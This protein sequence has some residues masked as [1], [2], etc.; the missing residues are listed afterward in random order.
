MG[1]AYEQRTHVVP[2]ATG[3]S[4]VRTSTQELRTMTNTNKNLATANA[5]VDSNYER[6][7]AQEIE[8]SRRRML[9]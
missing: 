1:S 3:G 8:A 4:V 5:N 6:R 7:R 9:S 2:G